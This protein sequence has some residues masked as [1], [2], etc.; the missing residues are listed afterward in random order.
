[1]PVKAEIYN[2]LVKFFAGVLPVFIHQ[3]KKSQ[4]FKQASIKVLLKY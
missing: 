2:G 1:M 3:G 4:V